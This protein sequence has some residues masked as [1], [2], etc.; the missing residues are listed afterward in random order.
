MGYLTD[1]LVLRKRRGAMGRNL[2]GR[3][4]IVAQMPHRAA[5]CI[6]FPASGAVGAKT[7]CPR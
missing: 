7:V 3:I 1:C 4:E 6:D 2:P 5:F